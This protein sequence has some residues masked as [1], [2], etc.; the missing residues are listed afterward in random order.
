MTSKIKNAKNCKNRI[1]KVSKLNLLVTSFKLYVIKAMIHNKLK[2][3]HF[4]M[5]SQP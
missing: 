1:V 2:I 4:S 3:V 5:N